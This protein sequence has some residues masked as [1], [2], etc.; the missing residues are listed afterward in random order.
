MQTKKI[1]TVCILWLSKDRVQMNF[2]RIYTTG[3]QKNRL[4]RELQIH[5]A[6]DSSIWQS[7]YMHGQHVNP[8][9]VLLHLPF[10]HS[11]IC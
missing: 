7:D 6:S 10:F 3:N 2:Q 9:N 11:A 5:I 1:L 8:T 4:S